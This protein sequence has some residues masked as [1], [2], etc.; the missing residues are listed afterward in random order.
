LELIACIYS[1]GAPYLLRYKASFVSFIK[2]VVPD[3]ITIHCAIHRQAHASDFMESLREVLSTVVQV[4]NFIQ[5]RVLKHRLFKAY[6]EEIGSKQT[7]CVTVYCISQ[8]AFSKTVVSLFKEI[9][10][11]LQVVGPK[12]AEKF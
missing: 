5:G 2:E 11:F 12:A 9:A 4:A 10:V 3:V 1:A 6:C 7:N 8:M